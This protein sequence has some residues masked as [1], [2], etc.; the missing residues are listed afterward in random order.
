MSARAAAI[1][2]ADVRAQERYA[3]DLHMPFPLLSDADRTAYQAYGLGH[4]NTW[5]VFGTRTIWTY[6]KLMARGRRFRG[7]QADPY[8]LGGD[9]VIDGA[10]VLRFA[11][12]SREP[13]DR[14][15]MERLLEAIRDASAVP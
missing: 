11:Y 2:F 5:A 13:S 3:R 8:Q 7:I 15:T 1:S 4:G 6:V 10:G 12:R 14:P 9:F